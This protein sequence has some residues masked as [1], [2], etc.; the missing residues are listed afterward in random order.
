MGK[1]WLR[2][3]RR[4]A[5]WSLV[6]VIALILGVNVVMRIIGGRELGQAV[7]QADAA[8]PGWHWDELNF[9]KPSIPDAENA[10]STMLELADRLSHHGPTMSPVLEEIDTLEPTVKLS[11]DQAKR[12][13]AC[14]Q[15]LPLARDDV[16]I[17]R[18]LT[19]ADWPAISADEATN[20]DDRWKRPRR[21]TAWCKLQV[22]EDCADNQADSAL[23]AV[24]LLFDG[25]R[26]YGDDSMLLHF[27][28]RVAQ[29]R[30]GIQ[31]LE[32]CLAQFQRIPVESLRRTRERLNEEANRLNL[33]SAMRRE[34]AWLFHLTEL[35]A[36][37][38]SAQVLKLASGKDTSVS[39][40]DP[41]NGIWRWEIRGYLRHNQALTL[42]L[43]NKAV[44]N[45][46]QPVDR[47][48]EKNKQLEH[49]T[50]ITKAI[51]PIWNGIGT[52][53][54]PMAVKVTEAYLRVIGELRCAQLA[55]ATEEFRIR[56]DRWPESLQE[57]EKDLNLTIP[58][59]PFDGK[60]LRYAK[61]EDGV[62]I[63]TIGPNEKDNGGN[64]PKN[65]DEWKDLDYGFRLWDL[66]YRRQAPAPVGKDD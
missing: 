27:L 13:H 48:L 23:E 57:M 34:R 29:D 15:S 12:L 5:I 61:R 26:S 37:G 36:E 49:E 20:G 40:F 60:P 16:R 58:N 63:Y 39:S 14:L 52:L 19:R 6:A 4:L 10:C 53:P 66:K 22:F 43:M 64:L 54:I 18:R 32:R 30:I 33:S 3:F 51:N 50:K 42:D 11:D 28:V 25:A 47:L 7:E 45:S 55:L 46:K 41:I 31:C 1:K 2:R 44:E 59:D 56:R 24:D 62:T 21:L 9:R 38:S 65:A 35:V 17:L 8:D